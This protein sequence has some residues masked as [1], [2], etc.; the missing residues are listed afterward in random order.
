MNKKI[1]ITIAATVIVL[2][3]IVFVKAKTNEGDLKDNSS[4]L[5]NVAT[6][7]IYDLMMN[8]VSRNIIGM[9]PAEMSSD[10]QEFYYEYLYEEPDDYDEYKDVG[11]NE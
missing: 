3:V 4:Q 5:N 7:N 10:E 8:T 2:F 6:N 9:D 1:L 11:V